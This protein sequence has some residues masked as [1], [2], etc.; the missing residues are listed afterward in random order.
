MPR[1]ALELRGCSNLC[2]GG[3]AAW[4]RGRAPTSSRRCGTRSV[5]SPNLHVPYL[6]ELPARGPGA[7]LVGRAAGAARRPSRRPA[8]GRLAA[9]RPAGPRP[10][11]VR[12]PGC[13]QD[14]DVLAEVAE[15]YAG[16]V[17]DPV[18]PG[19]WT[20]A[21]APPPARGWSVPSSTPGACAT[22][23]ASLAEGLARHV[24]EVRRLVP[25]AEVVVQLDEPSLPG[26][27]RRRAAHRRAGTARLR[28]V[29]EPVAVDGLRLCW[30]RPR[31]GAV[32]ALVHCCAADAPVEVSGPAGADG[33]SLDVVAARSSRLGAGGRRGREPASALW[34]GRGA[35]R[36]GA[37]APWRP[38]PTRS[39]AGG[40]LGRRGLARPRSTPPLGS[41][42]GRVTPA[43][44]LA[45]AD[46]GRRAVPDP[47]GR[48]AAADCREPGRRRPRAGP[49]A[50]QRAGLS[51]GSGR[52][53]RRWSTRRW[54]RGAVGPRGSARA[55]R[56]PSPTPPAQ[57]RHAS[58]PSRSTSTSSAT[59]CW[60]RRR[61][62]TASST[63]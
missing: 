46:L 61:S 20:L 14:L 8:A 13:A 54:C 45:G 34:A 39:G 32:A 2:P 4:A 41:A 52:M 21:A 37:A 10:A 9:G 33:L 43:C 31:G 44:G 63:R 42:V 26:G 11:P 3:P 18:L 38:P 16:P 59:T 25:G 5:S 15:D 12:R 35:D 51:G 55:E 40:A 49:R 50:G 28:A 19:P 48:D 30:R 36:G 56:P 47:A 1:Q 24:A 57:R 60:T 53:A 22:S 7:D 58:W 29:D 27:A 6:P 23:S 62:P 17:Q